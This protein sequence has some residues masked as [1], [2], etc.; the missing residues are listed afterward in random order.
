MTA[1]QSELRNGEAILK[2]PR[3]SLV[4][5]VVQPYVLNTGPRPEPL[6]SQTDD[7]RGDREHALSG[8]GLLR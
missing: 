3:Y 2:E 8:P 7:V 5:H 1:Y 6:P 4:P